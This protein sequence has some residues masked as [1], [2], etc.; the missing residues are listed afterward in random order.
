MSGGFESGDFLFGVFFKRDA[1][2]DFFDDFLGAVGG[3]FWS[4][5][6]GPR[7]EDACGAVLVAPEL[8][9]ATALEGRG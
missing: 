8:G 6:R 3:S 9:P 1:F 4:D 5:F 2:G 7:D